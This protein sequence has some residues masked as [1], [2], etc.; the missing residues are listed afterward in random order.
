MKLLE[1]GLLAY[2]N[3]FSNKLNIEFGLTEGAMVK[4]EVFNA[5]GLRISRL[6][7]GYIE[8]GRY[9]RFEFVPSSLASQML[10]YQVTVQDKVYHGKVLYTK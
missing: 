5:M 1:A 10:I 8:G 6:F 2:P 7:E 3:P 9:N 4:V